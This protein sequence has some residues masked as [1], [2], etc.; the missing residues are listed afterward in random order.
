[1]VNRSNRASW[2]NRLGTWGRSGW[3]SVLLGAAIGCVLVLLIGGLTQGAIAGGPD[4]QHPSL[5][6]A[7]FDTPD[8][9]G[10]IQR[11]WSHFVQT[12]QLWAMLIGLVLG[13][14]IRQATTYG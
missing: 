5:L 11:F 8:F 9:M 7:Q 1:M 4:L 12:G 2:R 6:A 3:G 13:Y 10:Q 14:I